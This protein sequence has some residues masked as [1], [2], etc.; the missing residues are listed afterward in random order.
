MK[1]RGRIVF[2]DF[3]KFYTYDD[4]KRQIVPFE[5]LNEDLSDMADTYKMI[6]VSDTSFWLVR[7]NE[8]TLINY[9][10]GTYIVREKIP[11][12]ILNNPPNKGRG[13]V[14]VDEN[15]YRIFF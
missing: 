4:I 6:S 10:Q 7:E 9:E 2:S 3:H 15:A 1:L 5:Q 13:N 11:F 8:Y 14:Y 12:G